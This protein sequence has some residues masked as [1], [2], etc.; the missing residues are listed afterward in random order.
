MRITLI[1]IK[2]SL[3]FAFFLAIWK[4]N[5]TTSFQNMNFSFALVEMLN[6]I[7]NL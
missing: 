5:D 1:S 7:E 3:T 2:I 6:R 4:A